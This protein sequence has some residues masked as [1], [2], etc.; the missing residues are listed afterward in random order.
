SGG[1]L[2]SLENLREVPEPEVVV[3]DRLQAVAL[4]EQ[5]ADLVFGLGHV[6]AGSDLDRDRA[7]RAGVGLADAEHLLFRGR[8]RDQD[9]IVLILPPGA[10]SLA[11]QDG[12][13]GGRHPLEWDA[14][15]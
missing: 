3:L 14:Q 1:L 11:R 2:L 9:E 8:Q 12:D 13:D 5:R 4:A 6:L 15:V 7:D 10:L